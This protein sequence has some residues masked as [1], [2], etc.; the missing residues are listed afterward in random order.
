MTASRLPVE[1]VTHI[2]QFLSV[3]DRKEAALVCQNWYEASLDPILQRDII[4]HFYASSAALTS[5]AIPS[6]SKRRLPHLVL[7]DFDSSL[8]AKAVVLKSCEQFGENLKSLSLRGSELT[9][10]TFVELLSH[11]KNL[12]SLDLSC[13]NTLFMTGTLLEMN[14]DIQLLKS[15]LTNVEEVNMSSI[16]HLTDATFNRIMTVCENVEK[17]SLMS[18]PI[19]FSSEL[20]KPTSFRFANSSV[21]TFRNMMDFV[22]TQ[23]CL[24]SLNLSRTQI[25]DSNLKE[26]VSTPELQLQELILVGC[27]NISD[28]GISSVCKYQTR[29]SL[30]DIKECPDLTNSSLM[31]ISACLGQL[32][33]LNMHKCKQV[34]DKA[35]STMTKLEEMQTLDL[36]ECH[37]V[38]SKGLIAGLCGDSISLCLTSLNVSCTEAD[39]SFVEKACKNLPALTYLDLSS[40]FKVTDVSVHAIS[41]SLK[42]LRYLRLAF[43]H[44]VT[45]LGLLGICSGLDNKDSQIYKDGY[46]HNMN[47]RKYQSTVIFKK[48]EKSPTGP[49]NGDPEGKT[50]A[51]KPLAL[52][53]LAG[54]RHLDL[55]ACKKL[56][57]TSLKQVLKFPE[58]HFLG[59][60]NLKELSDDGL[61]KIVYQN[62]SIEELDLT[63]CKNI[64]DF[65]MDAVT[66]HLQRLKLLNVMGCDLITDKTLGYIKRHCKRLRHLDVS[67]CGGI[68]HNAIN[69]LEIEM[70]S[71]ISVHKRMIGS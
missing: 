38:S 24:R 15:T 2:M 43:C 54:L 59:L 9:E 21:L 55:S 6:L 45:D 28:E 4:L 42:H 25:E 32:K 52:S 56:S 14:A 65:A 10:K 37:L 20:F 48:P 23:Q 58:L 36:S 39:D 27:R 17:V 1:V 12:V 51:I 66:K 22:I 29:L 31:T 13:C 46:E 49:K 8:N 70:P 69:E 5:K 30:L 7:N 57:D 34:S 61:V 67:F 16:R 33:H 71:L 40:C 11:C 18:A 3:S 41:K 64:S 53:N 26:L 62:P 19:V 60:G 47:V 68:S 63:Q 50:F 44:E 35:V